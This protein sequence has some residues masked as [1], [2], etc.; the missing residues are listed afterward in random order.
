MTANYSFRP[1]R[2]VLYAALLVL[3]ATGAVAQSVKKDSK[4]LHF[5]V[6]LNL[7]HPI[8]Y[9]NMFSSFGVGVDAAILHPVMDGLSVGGRVNY[10]YFMGRT[11]DEAFTSGNGDHFKASGLYDFFGEA[12][13][14]LPS[15]VV[16]GVDLGY[17]FVSFNGASDGAFAQKI[18]VGYELDAGN[19]PLVIAGFYENT[20]YH[21]NAGI[22]VSLRL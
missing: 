17:G 11:A 20:V 9:F 3:T 2:A 12:Q 6:G 18:Y 10:G 1:F 22:R 7:Y 19:L 21:K 16:A 5:E 8:R 4:D 15:N 13:Y 14:K